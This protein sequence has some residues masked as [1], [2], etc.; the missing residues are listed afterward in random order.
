VAGPI[1]LDWS[2][3]ALAGLEARGDDAPAVSGPAERDFAP[4]RLVVRADHE[5]EAL[6]LVGADRA[7]AHEQRRLG[8]GAAH[9]QLDELAGD[10]AAVL[11]VEHRAHAH[12]AAARVHRRRADDR[13]VRRETPHPGAAVGNACLSGAR[14]PRRRGRALLRA[15]RRRLPGHYARRL[16]AADHRRKEHRRQHHHP[17]IGAQLFPDHREN[18]H[19]QDQGN[20]PGPA[21]RARTEQEGNSRAVHEQDL[22]RLP[23]LRRGRGR[24]GVLRQVTRA[25]LAGAVRDGCRTAQGAV[26]HQSDHLAGA[27]RRAPTAGSPRARRRPRARP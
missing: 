14:L 18:L 27:G 10:E 16:V 11:V 9:A 17:A 2:D 7:L 23:R 12:R 25:A 3:D 22:P 5:H 20:L 1:D 13:R 21:D 6:V 26:A 19:P 8:L 15:P 24:R 4:D